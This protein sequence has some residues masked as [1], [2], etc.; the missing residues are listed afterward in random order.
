[1]E[2]I[3]ESISNEICDKVKAKIDIT[4][5]FKEPPHKS[6]EIIKQGKSVLEKWKKE[7][8]STRREIEA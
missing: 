7:F 6:I 1:M 5:I 3:L 2:D 8:D 4:K